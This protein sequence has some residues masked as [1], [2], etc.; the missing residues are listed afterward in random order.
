MMPS[1]GE[2]LNIGIASVLVGMEATM[3]DTAPPARKKLLHDA[4]E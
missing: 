1:L 4:P 3:S 2:S